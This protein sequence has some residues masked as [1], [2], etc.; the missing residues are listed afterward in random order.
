MYKISNILLRSTS[1]NKARY[2]LSSTISF[3]SFKLSDTQIQEAIAN[4]PAQTIADIKEAQWM[5]LIFA[6]AEAQSASINDI[7]IEIQPGVLLGHRNNPISTPAMSPLVIGSAGL[8][9]GPESAVLTNDA[10][11]S[12]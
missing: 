11:P 10:S 6:E 9:L 4:V 1:V 12:F 2:T 3:E 7:E 5:A 8:V